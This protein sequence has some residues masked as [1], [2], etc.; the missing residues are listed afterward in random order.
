MTLTTVSRIGPKGQFVLKKNLRTEAGLQ[1]GEMVEAQV[2]KE[3]ILIKPFDADKLLASIEKTAKKLSA[4][5]PKGLT[6]A[7]AVRRERK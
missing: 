4:M 1:E 2:T 6:A 5:W 7:E 3:G